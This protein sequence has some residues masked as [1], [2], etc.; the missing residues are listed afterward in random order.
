[1]RRH[2]RWVLGECVLEVIQKEDLSL[3]FFS[4]SFRS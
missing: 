2:G 4:R 3:V 1:M